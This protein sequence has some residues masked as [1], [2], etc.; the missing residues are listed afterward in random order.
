[1][2]KYLFLLL[3][4]G[5]TFYAQDVQKLFDSANELYQKENYEKAID[6]YE[7][8]E[9]LNFTSSALFYNLG[10]AHYKLNQVGPAIFYYEKALQIDPNNE[11]VKNNL[12]FAKRL[13]LDS[14]EE[15]PQTFFQKIDSNYLKS[16]SYNEWA[17]CTVVFT[18]LGSLFFVF[19][20]FTYNSGTKRFFFVS[21]M[22]SF[23]LLFITLAITYQQFSNS[24]KY[25]EAIV[26]AEETSV[27]NAPTLNSEDLFTL[28]EGTK[29]MVLDTIDK[30]KKIKIADGKQGWIIG[31]EVKEL[32]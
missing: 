2:K 20:Y 24:S 23:F 14:I 17:I 29:V 16:L 18:F 9:R 8:V 10:N 3:L 15:L 30:W 11:D 12:V 13:A 27:M 4:V 19:F 1:M 6:L 7:D 21:S 26:F 5:T 32:N 22:F 25:K 28:H 31:T